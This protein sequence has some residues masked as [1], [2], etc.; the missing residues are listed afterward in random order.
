MNIHQP[1]ENPEWKIAS[2][3]VCKRKGIFPNS[4]AYDPVSKTLRGTVKQSTTGDDYA[5]SKGLLEC[6]LRALD[7]GATDKGHPV[8]RATMEFVDRDS[9]VVRECSVETMR[10]HLKGEFKSGRHGPYTWVTPADFEDDL[11]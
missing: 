5:M 9:K 11:F 6:S 10:D 4:L 1:I 8:S 2:I 3:N 7:T